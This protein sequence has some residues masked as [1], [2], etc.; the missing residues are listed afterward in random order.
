MQDGS[1]FI[2]VLAIAAIGATI[3]LWR[4]LRPLDD[5]QVPAAEPTDSRPE[6]LSVDLRDRGDR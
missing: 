2:A 3:A 5:E 6:I 4:A 1:I